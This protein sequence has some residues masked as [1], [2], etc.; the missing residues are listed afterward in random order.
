MKAFPV[1]NEYNKVVTNQYEIIDDGNHYFQS[2][3]KIVAKVDKFGDVYLDNDWNPS[4]TT[5]KFRNCFL[6]L[7]TSQIRERIKSGE[8]KVVNLNVND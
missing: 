7:S 2:Y 5:A 1:Y 8:I 4:Q 6:D 3:D